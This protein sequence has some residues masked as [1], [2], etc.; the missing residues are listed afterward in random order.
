MIPGI[1]GR[2]ISSAFIRDL[3]PSLEGC[4][5]PPASTSTALDRWRQQ[6]D[7][8]LGPASSPRAIADTAVIPLLSLLELSVASR[9]DETALIR[10]ATTW[11]G[12]SGPN[13]LVLGWDQPLS[14]IWRDTVT[15]SI[16][17]GGRWAICTNG[18][19]L[20]IVDA[21][22]TWSRDYL[23]IDLAMAGTDPQIQLVIWTL[24]RGPVIAC[25][26]SALD[27]A[28]DLSAQY[29]ADICRAL[30]R[31]VLHGLSC[32]LSHLANCDHAP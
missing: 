14:A 29:G 13:V 9:V 24:V 28:A 5:P 10:I 31:S 11:A 2:L 4:A 17:A 3:L 30:G 20:R 7:Q 26:P 22:R 25:S 8:T 12:R 21:V 23:E 19:A 18:S 27:R 16:R 6:V 15:A 32:L 1:G